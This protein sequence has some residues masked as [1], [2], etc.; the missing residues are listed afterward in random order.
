MKILQVLTYYRP[1]TSGLT[2][3]VERLVRTLA[4][5]GHQVTV[6]TSQYEPGLPRQ[7]TR[8]G[9]QIIRVPVWFRVSKG[10]IMPTFGFMAWKLVSENEV[11][12]LHLP[13]FDAA[14][15]AFRGRVLRKPTVISYHSDLVLPPGAFNRFVD[16]VVQFMNNLTAVFAHRIGAYTQDFADHSPYLHRFSG[17]VQV[18]YPPVELPGTT[19]EKVVEFKNLHN[20]AGKHPVIGMATRF[21]AEKGVEILLEA[22]PTIL[23]RYPDAMV[24]YAGQYQGVWK[25]DAYLERLLP[26]IRK[27]QANG[28]W[29]F[30]GNL[31]LEEIATFYP[32]LDVLVVPSLNSTETFGLVQI[33]AMMN[34][35]PTVASDLPGVRQPPQMTG[36]G[37]VVPVGDADAL[38]EAILRILK[39]PERYTG[40]PEAIAKQFNP[41]TNAAAYEAIYQELQKALNRDPV[42]TEVQ[43]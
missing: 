39:Y 14:G 11:I 3:Y 38:A 16:Q 22:M 33:E 4:Q 20:P 19:P 26:M 29:Q 23:E 9:V 32:N 40:D 13:Q 30:V 21:A 15:V 27:L 18:I 34:G 17:K 42:G 10:V 28:Q 41:H 2:I 8:D 24:L 5:R 36:M 1:H 6:L 25:E 31:S 43:R 35:V 37:E 12:H 7:E